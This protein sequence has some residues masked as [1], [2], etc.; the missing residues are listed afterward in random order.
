MIAIT[1]SEGRAVA[2]AACLPPMK[3]KGVQGGNKIRGSA[4]TL[5]EP[6]QALLALAA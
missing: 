6:R 5:S 1:K 2:G 4:A 3:Q